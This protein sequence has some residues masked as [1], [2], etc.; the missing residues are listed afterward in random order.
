R[1]RPRVDRNDLPL[2]AIGGRLAH[3]LVEGIHGGEAEGAARRNLRDVHVVEGFHVF[4][5]RLLVGRERTLRAALY[6]VE[7][8]V[9]QRIEADGGIE[10]RR[11]L[12]QVV[13]DLAA[14]AEAER[15]RGDIGI[16]AD[17]LELRRTAALRQLPPQRAQR[18]HTDART[19]RRRMV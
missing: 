3:V 13:V 8:I 19:V 14:V 1:E 2:F 17:G 9:P 12:A 15:G 7:Q 18:I 16:G 11:F 4:G 10:A 5:Q 6:Q